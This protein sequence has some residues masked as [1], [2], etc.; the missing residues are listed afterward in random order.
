MKESS[1][2]KSSKLMSALS[3]IIEQ[4]AYYVA[5]IAAILSWVYFGSIPVAIG[6]F[7]IGCLV[8]WAGTSLIRRD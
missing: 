1:D 5:L 8:S 7:V 6:V 2:R 4:V 3:S